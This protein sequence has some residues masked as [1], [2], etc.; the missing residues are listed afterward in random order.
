MSKFLLIDTTDAKA[1]EQIKNIRM[2]EPVVNKNTKMQLTNIPIR[3]L[4]ENNIEKLLYLKT[5]ETRMPFGVTQHEGVTRPKFNM[6]ASFSDI[7]TSEAQNNTLNFLKELD[8][9]ILELACENKEWVGR[10]KGDPDAVVK[11]FHQQIVKNSKHKNEDGSDKYPPQINI[12]LP[13]Y[14][15]GNFRTKV[16]VDKTTKLPPPPES[17]VNNSR[18]SCVLNVSNMY[19][20]GGKFGMTV[21]AEQIKTTPVQKRETDV[22]LLSDSEDEE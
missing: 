3:I 10:E 7:G 8:K 12:K 20:V 18:C 14:P 1:T 21:E 19:L 13:T 22:C 2:G 6:L 9:R 16:F 15:D 11:A 17:V 4:D 5:C